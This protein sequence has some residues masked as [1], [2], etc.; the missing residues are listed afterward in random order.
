MNFHA[1]RTQT[2]REDHSR[3]IGVLL[4]TFM[5]GVSVML[6]NAVVLFDDFMLAM[7]ATHKAVSWSGWH[8]R[9]YDSFWLIIPQTLIPETAIC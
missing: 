5:L 7:Q 4:F 3:I 2:T 9:V 1:I 8:L 6:Q